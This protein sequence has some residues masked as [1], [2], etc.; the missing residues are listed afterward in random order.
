MSSNPI[1]EIIFSISFAE[2]IKL[3]CLQNFV[4][5]DEIKK[6]FP[7]IRPGY[8]A[9]L[10]ATSDGTPPVTNVQKSGYVLKCDEPYNRILQAKVGLLA[11]HKTKEYK[12]YVELILELNSYWEKFQICTGQLIVTNVSL[13]YLNFID[14][15]KDEQI[16]D[17]VNIWTES[18]FTEVKQSFTSIKYTLVNDPKTEATI[19]VTKGK[20]NKKE[21]II[22]DINLNRRIEGKY[23]ENISDA[24]GDMRELKN[25]IFQECITEKTKNKYN[26]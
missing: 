20:D 26:L 12:S 8:N 18:P 2:N 9:N 24:F 1:K 16:K 25:S 23:Y 4:E 3:D 5:I 11:F 22:L 13:R 17:F 7:V 10:K 6:A 14:I 19:A 21:G 15:D